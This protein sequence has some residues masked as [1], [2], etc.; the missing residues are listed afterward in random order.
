MHTDRAQVWVCVY[1]SRRLTNLARAKDSS[2]TQSFLSSKKKSC[3]LGFDRS[4]FLSTRPCTCCFCA[5]CSDLTE[6]CDATRWCTSLTRTWCSL[7]SRLGTTCREP[8]HPPCSIG[9]SLLDRLAWFS[10]DQLCETGSWALCALLPARNKMIPARHDVVRARNSARFE[11]F[12]IKNSRPSGET[13]ERN[14]K[15]VKPL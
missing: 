8:M 5:A 6:G 13:Q 9:N 3:F 4:T 2:S 15:V 11:E 10:F 1:T 14:A 12:R 7:H